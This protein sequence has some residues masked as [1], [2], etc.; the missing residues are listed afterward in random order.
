VAVKRSKHIFSETITG[1]TEHKA[2]CN[3]SGIS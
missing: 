3:E 2:T 1:G